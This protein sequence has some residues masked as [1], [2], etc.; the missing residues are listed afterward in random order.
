VRRA[1]DERWDLQALDAAARLSQR[2]RRLIAEALATG[3]VTKW[4]HPA[5]SRRYIDS[6]DDF[7]STLE[8]TRR[9]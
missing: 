7:W 9:E 5:G 2:R 1:A 4:D 3:C 8:R 6:G